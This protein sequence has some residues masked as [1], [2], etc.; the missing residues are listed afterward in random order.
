MNRITVSDGSSWPRPHLES[1]EELGVEWKIRF[2]P[3]R[4]TRSDL[5]EAAAIISAYEHLV[6]GSTRAKRDLV[7]RDI[8][9]ALREE[10]DS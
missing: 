1:D 8:R 4:P 2:A 7:C 6:L 9:T 3:H 5:L 10:S